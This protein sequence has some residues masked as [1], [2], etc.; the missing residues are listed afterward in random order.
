MPKIT[1]GGGPTN[2]REAIDPAVP[3][4]AP[5]AEL[6]RD[7]DPHAPQQRPG[8]HT[9]FFGLDRIG[10]QGPEPLGELA[11]EDESAEVEGSEEDADPAPAVEPRPAKRGGR[12]SS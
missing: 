5:A 1:A 12:K 11:T 7:E 4:S 6:T 8:E 10:E 2:V 3:T 9:T